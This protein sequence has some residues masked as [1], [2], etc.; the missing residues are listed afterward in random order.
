MSQLMTPF[1]GTMTVLSLGSSF[2]PSNYFFSDFLIGS[3]SWSAHLNVVTY[4]SIL[5]SLPFA[6]NAT[7]LKDLIFSCA[8]NIFYV[9]LKPMSFAQSSLLSFCGHHPPAPADDTSW[10]FWTQQVSNVI[11]DLFPKTFP[12]LEFL[13]ASPPSKSPEPGTW[14]T[15]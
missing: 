3:L 1:L 13:T 8:F 4:G 2:Y 5:G 6:L 7:S 14:E 15:S 9:P 11:H 10:D 12:S